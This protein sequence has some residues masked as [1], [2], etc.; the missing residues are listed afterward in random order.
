VSWRDDAE[1][2]ERAERRIGKLARISLAAFRTAARVLDHFGYLDFASERVTERGRWLADCM[3]IDFVN[4]RGAR[5]RLFT[6]L[7]TTQVAAVIAAL[8]ATRIA[9][10]RTWN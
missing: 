5:G 8:A 6:S 1:D 7:K 2:I 9:T 4:W 10:M 3:S